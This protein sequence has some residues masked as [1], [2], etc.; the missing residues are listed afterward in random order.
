MKLSCKREILQLSDVT[1]NKTGYMGA[2]EVM[3]LGHVRS[4]LISWKK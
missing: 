3:T 1:D 2:K 4:A